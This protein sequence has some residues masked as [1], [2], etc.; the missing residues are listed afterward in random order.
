[1]NEAKMPTTL[2]SL[3]DCGE[4]RFCAVDTLGM[5]WRWFDE[6]MVWVRNPERS[7]PSE[8]AD[9]SLTGR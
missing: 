8:D 2:P 7:P 3:V 9:S 4:F 1:M 6:D 5:V